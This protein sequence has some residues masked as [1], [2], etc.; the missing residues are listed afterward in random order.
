M[1]LL[2]MSYFVI[3]RLSQDTQKC[4]H[5]FVSGTLHICEDMK[6]VKIILCHPSCFTIF[7]W[8]E[9]TVFRFA[10]IMIPRTE[11]VCFGIDIDVDILV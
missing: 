11:G 1:S 9:Y 7:L 4:N 8:S 10:Q 5:S 6:A 2:G 3:Y